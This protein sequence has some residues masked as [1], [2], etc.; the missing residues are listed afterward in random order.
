VLCV[1]NLSRFAQPAQL[2][3]GRWEGAV[4]IELTGRVP[5]PAITT[6]PYLLTLPPYG[7]YWFELREDAG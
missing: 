4:P 2:S 6:A 7:I 5:F 3:L 1:H